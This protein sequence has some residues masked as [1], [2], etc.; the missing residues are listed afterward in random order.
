MAPN[1]GRVVMRTAGEISKIGWPS[2]GIR[3]T[4]LIDHSLVRR[5]AG[6]VVMV[7]SGPTGEIDVTIPT[8]VLDYTTNSR[9][10]AIAYATSV[11]PP[12]DARPYSDPMKSTHGFSI[13][14]GYK[15]LVMQG[16]GM[17]QVTIHRSG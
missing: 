8:G 5:R 1:N 10:D 12:I 2:D 14:S 3:L 7:N 11:E 6:K 9:G 17:V 16:K 15:D 4:A 13:P